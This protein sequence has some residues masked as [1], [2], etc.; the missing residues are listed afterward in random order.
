LHKEDFAP[1]QFQDGAVHYAL[2]QRK[3]GKIV[4]LGRNQLEHRVA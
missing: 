1:L 3:K 4:V 2:S